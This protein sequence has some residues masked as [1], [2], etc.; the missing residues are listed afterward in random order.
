MGLARL[1]TSFLLKDEL[2]LSPAT[3]AALTGIA[4][5]PWTIKPLYGWLSDTLPIA[6]SHRRSYLALA[7]LLGGAA[8]LYLAWAAE[9]VPQVIGAMLAGSLSLAVADV[10]AD[11]L[12]VTWSRQMDQSGSLQSLS[13]GATALGGLLTAYWGGK[14]LDWY[15]PQTVFAI[16]A[17]LPLLV[18]LA[19]IA[20]DEPTTTAAPK[21]MA[22][23]SLVWQALRQPRVYLPL[24]FIF[25]WQATPNS[26]TA[27]FYF[28]TN[29]LGFG[30]EFLGRVRLATSLAA[31]IGVAVFQRYL[32]G[33]ALTKLFLG[34]TVAS[35]VLGLTSLILI[36]HTNRLWGIPDTWFSL[37]DS[38]ILTVAGQLS[39][40]PL[41]V[42]A[43]QLC[44]PGIEATLFALLMSVLN[45]AGLLSQE[46]GALLME[47]LGI[48]ETQFDQ[49]WL[50]VLI[51]NLSSLL[52]LPLLGWLEPTPPVAIA[53]SERE[54]TL[55]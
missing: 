18:V 6:N 54:T 23:L 32:R 10:I 29:D 41:L 3:V 27:F 13:W 11:A 24:A 43:A 25:L 40:M 48:T 16:T 47:L 2:G 52:P 4:L 46:L 7:G 14:L 38:V 5:I 1:S 15:S 9:T 20:I 39:F 35:S 26:E 51:T 44:P 55:V 33:V 31:L 22:Q 8:W 42:L 17:I 49:L 30:P 37:G 45:L 21:P 19:T 12:I 50:L 34:L 53:T 36:S 28:V